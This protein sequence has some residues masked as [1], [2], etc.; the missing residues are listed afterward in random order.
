MS[1]RVPWLIL[2]AL[3]VIGF[4]NWR[5]DHAVSH[6]ATPISGVLPVWNGGPGPGS[7]LT[8]FVPD[9][10]ERMYEL[11]DWQLSSD[12]SNNTELALYRPSQELFIQ[13]GDW[14]KCLYYNNHR[15]AAVVYADGKRERVKCAH[16]DTP[17]K[18]A[19][20]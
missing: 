15:V 12:S 13:G 6:H 8:E 17:A 14:I 2:A 5:L 19:V 7:A 4:V 18:G 11:H 1:D 20:Q 9:L 10:P 16:P 3:V